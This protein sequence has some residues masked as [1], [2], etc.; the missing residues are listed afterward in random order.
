MILEGPSTYKNRTS[1]NLS[2][3]MIP[4]VKSQ[5]FSKFTF[6]MQGGGGYQL[7]PESLRRALMQGG[8]FL[9]DLAE[10]SP[11]GCQKRIPGS[12]RSPFSTGFIRVCDMADS[13]VGNSENPNGFFII[14]EPF[15]WK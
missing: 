11:A 6:L 8:V 15:L 7:R 10:G 9:P 13:R 1:R 4:N 2:T 12:P 3:F 5:H 14:L